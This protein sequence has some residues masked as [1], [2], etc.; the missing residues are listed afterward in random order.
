MVQAWYMDNSTEDQRLQHH[1]TPP[2]FIDMN[3]LFKRTGVEYFKVNEKDPVNDDLLIK[4][5]KERCYSYEDEI[6][7]SEQCLPNYH[8]KLKNFFTEHLHTDEEIRL[9]LE[10]SGYFDVRDPSDEW[11]RI[12][13]QPGDMIIIPSGIYHRFTLDDKNY[14]KAKRYFIGEPVWTPHNRPADNMPCRQEYLG[15]LLKGF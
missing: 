6:T 1:R 14:I 3:E 5:K 4:L 12:F 9:V 15:K 13:V 11:I 8:E 7:C 2:K 10:G